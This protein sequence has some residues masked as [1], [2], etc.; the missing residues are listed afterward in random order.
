MPYSSLAQ[1]RYFNVNRRRLEAQG[2]N[3]GEW[4]AASKGKKLPK[5]VKKKRKAAIKVD[6]HIKAFG[7]EEGG[8]IKINVRK[9]F[10]GVKGTK[11][12]L[13]ELADT[14]YHETYHA[15]HPNATE[16]VTYKKTRSA[17]NEM[18]H[19]DKMRL[20]RK[21]LHYKAGAVKRKLK[22]GRGNVEP[23]AMYRKYKQSESVKKSVKKPNKRLGIIGL[24]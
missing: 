6:N 21:V 19:E 13:M 10:R 8:K 18:S 1:E 14:V 4:N 17:M 20:A 23:G 12:P 24:V 7:E 2:V 3:V 9:H 16:K 5:R 15:K 22:L 11:S